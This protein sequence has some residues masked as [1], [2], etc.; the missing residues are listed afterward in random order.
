MG[1][2]FTNVAYTQ[3]KKERIE[4]G[5]TDAVNKALAKESKN[6][7]EQTKQRTEQAKTNQQTRQLQNQYDRNFQK[8][9][10]S[11]NQTTAEDYMS[12]PLQGNNYKE[13]DNKFAEDQQMPTAVATPPKTISSRSQGPFANSGIIGTPSYSGNNYTGD[14]YKLKPA[15]FGNT[16]QQQYQQ[17]QRARIPASQIRDKFK[18]PERTMHQSVINTKQANIPTRA[19]F[20]RP[21]QQDNLQNVAPVQ[22]QRIQGTQKTTQAS[23]QQK[24]TPNSA[25]SQMQQKRPV[26][27]REARETKVWIDVNGKHVD[28]SNG[29]IYPTTGRDNS[30]ADLAPVEILNPNGTKRAKINAYNIPNEARHL[31]D[32]DNKILPTYTGSGR[33]TMQQ[34]QL[35]KKD[36]MNGMRSFDNPREWDYIYGVYN[37]GKVKLPSYTATSKNK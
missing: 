25:T 9:M 10:T 21:P 2:V 19:S 13:E 27:V 11:L 1:F 12:P 22:A 23:Y 20:Q 26:P 36:L 14:R 29:S 4:K 8:Q 5:V 7:A 31:S 6:K 37:A 28:T 34:H 18:K 24:T 17:Q 32:T 16:Q 30:S 15:G 35:M 3:S 33:T